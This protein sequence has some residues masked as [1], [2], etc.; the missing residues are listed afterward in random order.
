MTAEIK[1]EDFSSEQGFQGYQRLVDAK[2]ILAHG[3]WR[4]GASLSEK[5]IVEGVFWSL[6]VNDPL[7]QAYEKIPSDILESI[8]SITPNEKILQEH[9]RKLN[10]VCCLFAI[11]PE[12]VIQALKKIY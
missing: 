5:Q 3:G 11:K 1:R 12:I 2:C 4:G 8:P 10:I 7:I 6:L 9:I